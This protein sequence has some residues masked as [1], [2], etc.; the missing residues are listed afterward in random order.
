MKWIPASTPEAVLH[1]KY[2]N[3]IQRCK[4]QC[5]C[6]CPDLVF[7]PIDELFTTDID[8]QVTFW[9]TLTSVIVACA[10]HF[11]AACRL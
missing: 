10:G 3:F 1:D 2:H 4:G 11:Q 7:K 8:H 9:L 6:R 5:S